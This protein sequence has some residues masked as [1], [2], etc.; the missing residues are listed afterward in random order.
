MIGSGSP[1]DFRPHA[2]AE[3]IKALQLDPRSAEAHAA[4]GYA[5][6]YDWQWN[7]A[8]KEFRRAVELNPSYALV[9]TR[10]APR[11]SSDSAPRRG[12]IPSPLHSIASRSDGRS[13]AQ[14]VLRRNADRA[15]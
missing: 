2:A 10:S 13:R 14:H 3:A 4:L 15:A 5:R 9:R 7:E 8:E 6:H 11:R 1:R 12:G